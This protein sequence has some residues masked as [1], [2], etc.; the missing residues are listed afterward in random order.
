[1]SALPL[2]ADIR[3]SIRD[4]RLVPTSEVAASLG[5]LMTEEAKLRLRFFDFREFRR[6]RKTF[7]GW[8]RDCVGIGRTP[9]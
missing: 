1:M 4:V 7:E 6:W 9:C 5:C 2:K 8:C 3:S